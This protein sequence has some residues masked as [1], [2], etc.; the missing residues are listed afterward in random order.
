M[1]DKKSQKIRRWSIISAISLFIMTLTAGYA[2]GYVFAKI[3]EVENI[4]ATLRNI[5]N[6][7]SLYIT[8]I[9]AWAIIFTTDLLV[10]YGFYVYLRPIHKGMALISGLVRLIYT[11]ILGVAIV[12]L[13]YRD[14]H[15]FDQIWSIGLFI[16]G[17]HLMV[18]GVILLNEKGILKILSILL[19]VAG[20]GYSLLPTLEFLLPDAQN[21]ISLL[22]GILILPMTVAELFFG[23]YLLIK[24]GKKTSQQPLNDY[25]QAF[26]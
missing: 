8:G 2:Y 3:Y 10:S 4:A 12:L 26:E 11:L 7:Y 20:V 22:E 21:L 9:L 17:F 24:G 19:I 6:N 5:E 23:I 13:I 15:M 25:V 16:F 18:T 1:K 14:M